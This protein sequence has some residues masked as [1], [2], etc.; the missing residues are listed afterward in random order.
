MDKEILQ[1]SQNILQAK[2]SLA[3]SSEQHLQIAVQLVEIEKTVRLSAIDEEIAKAKRE[4]AEGK[5]TAAA[6][7]EAEKKGAILKAEA[8]TEAQVKLQLIVERELTQHD[9][10]LVALADQQLRFRMDALHTA[11]QLATT[12]A[13]H[14]RI[15]L[16][17]LDAEIEQQRLQL[18]SNKRDAIRNGA[19][20]E[21]IDLIQKSIDNL[22]V[23]RAQVP[24]SWAGAGQSRHFRAGNALDR[25]CHAPRPRW[26]RIV[27][28]R[29]AWRNGYE[30]PLHQRRPSGSRR[31]HGAGQRRQ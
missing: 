15:Q 14:R 31:Q 20:Q 5:I 13:D 17:I 6:L 1:A 22:S 30:R 24:P 16:A 10:D 26:R 25:S 18:E 7:Q 2:L 11:D 23:Q 9:H 3:G 29:R 28:G 8:E 12:Q 27:H 19:K 4:R 21:E